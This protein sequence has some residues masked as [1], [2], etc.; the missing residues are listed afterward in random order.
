MWKGSHPVIIKESI[1]HE[2]LT[3]FKFYE[4]NNR[5]SKIYEVKMIE[6]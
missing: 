5:A 4:P 2:N 3:I 6:L 1:Y